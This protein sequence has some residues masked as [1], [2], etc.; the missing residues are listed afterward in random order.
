MRTTACASFDEPDREFSL[1]ALFPGSGED[2]VMLTATT[3][4]GGALSFGPGEDVKPALAGDTLTVNYRSPG[5][6]LNPFPSL[7]FAQV[8]PTGMPAPTLAPFGFPEVHLDLDPVGY[9]PPVIAFDGVT[10]PD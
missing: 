9:G 3:A 10:A 4:A 6:S 8:F 1:P 5:G 2:L 7:L